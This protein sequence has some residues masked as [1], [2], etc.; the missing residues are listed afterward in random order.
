V[1][2]TAHRFQ[3]MHASRA[4]MGRPF[5]KATTNEPEAAFDLAKHLID[6]GAEGV[7]IHD[8]QAGKS[9]DLAAFSRAFRVQ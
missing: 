3:I 4:L 1:S 7:Q 8:V 9:Y 2:Q 5:L 6:G